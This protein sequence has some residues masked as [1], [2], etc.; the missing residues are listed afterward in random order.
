M[1]VPLLVSIGSG[2]GGT[3]TL[4]LVVDGTGAPTE[5]VTLSPGQS[6][7]SL[8]APAV[9]ARVPC[10]RGPGCGATE[11]EDRIAENNTGYLGVVVREQPRVLLVAPVGSDPS[12]LQPG[13]D[14]PGGS[15]TTVMPP[16]QVPVR[17][18]PTWPPTTRSC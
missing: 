18:R 13:A 4:D 16:D 5:T 9:G 17:A 8:T 1:T 6:V 11:V 2:G 14:R 3:A 15:G 10:G 7:Y 12:R